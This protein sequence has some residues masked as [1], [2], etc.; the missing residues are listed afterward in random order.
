MRYIAFYPTAKGDLPVKLIYRFRSSP[1][2]LITLFTI[3]GLFLANSIANAQSFRATASSPSANESHAISVTSELVVVPVNVTDVNGNFVTGLT[4]NSFHLYDESQLQSLALFQQENAPVSVGLDVDHSSSM[5]TRLPN[6]ITAISAFAHSANTM[7][8]FFVADFND[9][10]AV[11]TLDRRA[12]T[13][14]S[15]ELEKAIGAVSR[16]RANRLIR[17]RCRGPEPFAT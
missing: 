11:E 10:I 16:A 12:F 5:E 6:V 3:C 7:D 8:E 1:C 13:N 2:H 15:V 9:R 17:R 14:D 4:E